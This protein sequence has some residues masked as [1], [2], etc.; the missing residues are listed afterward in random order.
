[1]LLVVSS[2]GD[3]NFGHQ[4]KY[5]VEFVVI[6]PSKRCVCVYVCSCAMHH[7]RPDYWMTSSQNWQL[8][9]YHT[10]E[11]NQTKNITQSIAYLIL[12]PSQK[13]QKWQILFYYSYAYIIYLLGIGAECW[14]EFVIMSAN[15]WTWVTRDITIMMRLIKIMTNYKLHNR[16]TKQKHKQ[17]WFGLL[18][19]R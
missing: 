12:I 4:I 16:P 11:L 10:V 2:A 8:Q 3:V 15:N 18:F 1:M 17:R 9:C 13:F 6:Q 5:G 7:V 19:S 14:S